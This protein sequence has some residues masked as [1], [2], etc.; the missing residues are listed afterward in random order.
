MKN[1]ALLLIDLQLDYFPGG[2][3]VLSEPE[4]ALNE[5]CKLLAAF[6][7]AGLPLVHVRHEMAPERD[8][9]FL[10][11]G[12]EGACIHPLVAPAACE[13]VETKAYPNAFF[14]TTLDQY[15]RNL[16]VADLVI[17]GMMTH[18]CVSATARA[19]MELG[20][21]STVVFDA[22]ATRSLS[23]EEATIPA[24]DV[25]RAHLAALSGVVSTI[26]R[27][28]AVLEMLNLNFSGSQK[29]EATA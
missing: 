12:T 6:R 20:Y 27:A 28:D 2:K 1:T 9:P 17:C 7:E 4:K 22:T 25:H 3:L 23:L 24:G 15:L 8:L 13:R 5:A 18:M 29:N 26:A 14:Q 11:K 16:G 10:Q 21:R 19:A